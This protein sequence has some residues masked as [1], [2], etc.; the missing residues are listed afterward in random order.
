MELVARAMGFFAG[1]PE[2]SLKVSHEDGPSYDVDLE[3]NP[4]QLKQSLSKTKP[5]TWFSEDA[6]GALGLGDRA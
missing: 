1:A 2:I 4:E 6:S 3:R 5:F